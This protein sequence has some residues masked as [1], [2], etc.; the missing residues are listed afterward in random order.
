M[1]EETKPN[2]SLSFSSE[3]MHISFSAA[4]LPI[5]KV[6]PEGFDEPYRI[7]VPYKFKWRVKIGKVECDCKEVEECYQPWYGFDWYHSEAC[8]LM[9][10]V[11]EKPQLKN[12]WCYQGIERIASSE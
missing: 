5:E 4:A 12:L 7:M 8:A 9:R 3:G 2:K 11:K 10:L 6:K 1:T